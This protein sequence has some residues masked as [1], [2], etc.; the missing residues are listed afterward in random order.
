MSDNTCLHGNLHDWR[1]LETRTAYD[2]RG[3]PDSPVEIRVI[4]WYCTRCRK[5]E[6]T[7]TDAR[8]RLIP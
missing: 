4:T 7:E 5:I 3:Q 2:Y 8:S 6:E 1:H